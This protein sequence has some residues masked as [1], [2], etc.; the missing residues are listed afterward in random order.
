MFIR[1]PNNC[2]GHLLTRMI[3]NFSCNPVSQFCFEKTSKLVYKFGKVYNDEK[4]KTA[5]H[6][7]YLRKNTKMAADEYE[8]KTK[9]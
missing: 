2:K 3:F 9:F 6:L 1:R 7:L 5:I 4:G 8:M